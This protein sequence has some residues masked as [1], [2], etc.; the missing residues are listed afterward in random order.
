MIWLS[1]LVA[2]RILS[3]LRYAPSNLL[4][5]WL[6]RR[7]R[8]KWGVLAMPVGAA[9]LVVTFLLIEAVRGG[10]PGWLNLFVLVTFFSGVMS[11][12]FGP[13]SLA[14]LAAVRLQE[15]RSR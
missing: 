4:L 10:G 5:T 8:L 2:A 7:D 13:I 14:L 6:R 1:M 12:A 15:R 9:E 11:L 3:V